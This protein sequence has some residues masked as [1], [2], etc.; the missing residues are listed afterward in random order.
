MNCAITGPIS[1][2]SCARC[3]TTLDG[4]ASSCLRARPT[5]TSAKC[6]GPVTSPPSWAD[7][8]GRKA[9]IRITCARLPNTSVNASLSAGMTARSLAPVDPCGGP[10]KPV[11]GGAPHDAAAS[12][13]PRPS[14]PTHRRV[15]PSAERRM[16]I[17]DPPHPPMQLQPFIEGGLQGLLPFDRYPRELR[18]SLEADL[19]TRLASL[20]DRMPE[21][22]A[23]V[24]QQRLHREV[25]RWATNIRRAL[26]RWEDDQPMVLLQRRKA[27]NRPRPQWMV[28]GLSD[29]HRGGQT[30]TRLCF[31]DGSAF[32]YKPRN[33]RAEIFLR[34]LGSRLSDISG[35]QVIST[36][37]AMTRRSHGWM[38]D[39]PADS[40]LPAARLSGWQAGIGSLL[41]MAYFL[42]LED[43][44]PGNVILH[45][46]RPH[47]ADAETLMTPTRRTPQGPAR[48]YAQL[49][50][51]SVYRTA[52]L[53][54]VWA[55][56]GENS[57]IPSAAGGLLTG[58]H[59]REN[60]H[61]ARSAAEKVEAAF[62]HTYWLVARHASDL[63]QPGPTL[64][65]IR[66]SYGRYVS[67]GTA[68]YEQICHLG[69]KASGYAHTP[70]A[71]RGIIT[72][73][74]REPSRRLRAALDTCERECRALLAGDIPV[75]HVKRDDVCLPGTGRPPLRVFEESGFSAAYKRMTQASDEHC[76]IQRI[77]IRHA[78]QA[79]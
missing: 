32:I 4:K 37:A 19:R 12:D 44:H 71:R 33:L 11:P 17:A 16:S 69:L 53:P 64:A 6:S 74:R 65:A 67:V 61:G 51:E 72:L 3:T 30:V 54:R 27:L 62:V 68:T 25:P 5:V 70:A 2:R 76:E 63:L 7:G 21:A 73:L 49:H 78:L 45:Q 22:P 24:L 34:Q 39:L 55:D 28:S 38:V 43:L 40:H 41:A 79:E 23:K 46:G 9:A 31:D 20:L 29:P 10:C 26:Q 66:R 13:D 56:F 57:S 77:C 1:S 8:T 35:E 42:G 14:K 52:L 60:R 75:C 48:L 58:L 59:F 50:E 15:I 36:A 18:T 47:V